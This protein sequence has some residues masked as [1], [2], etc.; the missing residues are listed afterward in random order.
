MVLQ[1]GTNH[2]TIMTMVTWVILRVLNRYMKV[3]FPAMDFWF[4][5]AF[6]SSFV[7]CDIV[8]IVRPDPT[9]V[10]FSSQLSNALL[11]IPLSTNCC[12]F[13]VIGSIL[14]PFNLAIFAKTLVASLYLP[15][16]MSQRGDSGINL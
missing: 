3:L 5:C 11:S 10:T 2:N 13:I 7:S 12:G 4:S 16:D 1:K 8:L 6:S 15:T 14:R 9:F